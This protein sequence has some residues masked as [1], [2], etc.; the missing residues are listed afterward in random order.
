MSIIVNDPLKNWLS[1]YEIFH[2]QP[3]SER[4]N[5]VVSL[6]QDI[7]ALFVKYGTIESARL[8]S[9]VSSPDGVSSSS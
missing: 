1:R 9:A 2:L 5:Y 3:S 6:L 7:K 8:R 4:S